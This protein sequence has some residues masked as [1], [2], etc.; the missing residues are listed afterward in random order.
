MLS[1]STRWP[2]MLNAQT[3]LPVLLSVSLVILVALSQL[4]KPVDRCLLPFQ[5]KWKLP[6]GPKGWPVIGNL[7]LYRKG[8]AGVRPIDSLPSDDL[9]Y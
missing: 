4:L 2:Q 7:L 3:I 1:N 5:K 6:P 9:V 8:E